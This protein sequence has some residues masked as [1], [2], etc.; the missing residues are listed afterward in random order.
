[1]S[2]LPHL[3]NAADHVEVAGREAQR[4]GPVGFGIDR[5]GAAIGLRDTGRKGAEGAW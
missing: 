4:F 1:M 3:V 5:D 2:K